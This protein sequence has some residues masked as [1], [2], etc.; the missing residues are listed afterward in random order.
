MTQ[1]EL[2]QRPGSGSSEA[3]DRLES[4]VQSAIDQLREARTSRSGMDAE[5]A[6][7]RDL[8]AKNEQQVESLQNEV[9]E[10]RAER[11]QVKARIE[12]LVGQIDELA[13][14]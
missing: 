1:E 5:V 9:A 6:R 7:L 2:A 11:Q 14:S 8:L 12:S 3:L 10:L 4:R 13:A